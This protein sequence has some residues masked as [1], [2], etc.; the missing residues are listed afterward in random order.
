MTE[1]SH[2]RHRSPGRY[3]P[4]SELT[5]IVSRASSPALKT[6]AVVAASGGLVAAFAIPATAVGQTT[7]AASAAVPADRSSTLLSIG[8]RTAEVSASRA[9]TRPALVAPAVAAPAA[10]PSFGALAFTAIQKPPPPPPP[11]PPPVAAPAARQSES[12]SRSTATRSSTT[13]APAPAPAPTKEAPV[14]VASGGVLDVAASLVGIPYKYGGTTT[15][16]FDCSGFTQYVFA[17]VGISLG[18][19]TYQQWAQTTAVSNPQPGDLVFYNG[20]SPTHVGIYAGNGMMYDSGRAG[21]PTQLRKVFSGVSG[22][23]RV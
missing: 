15:A 14:R 22:Y 10:V 21:L 8:E 23:G 11:P 18:R 16:G 3:N 13:T 20:P 2:G 19:T 17:Q 1:K 12:S 9:A 6:S 7:S 5:L 4:L